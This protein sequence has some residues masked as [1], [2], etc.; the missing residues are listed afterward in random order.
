MAPRNGKDNQKPL[1]QWF[2]KG[3]L[4]PPVS[5]RKKGTPNKL[6]T[7]LKKVIL[8]AAAMV[9]RDGRGKEGLHGY[10]CKLAIQQP[11]I[12]GRLLEKLIPMHIKIGDDNAPAERYETVEELRTAMEARGLPA[13]ARIID[14]TPTAPQNGD[15]P[16]YG[17]EDEDRK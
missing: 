9:G 3:H 12:Y 17:V 2:T 1:K 11:K 5:G 15:E 13:P 10:L 4:K 6:S 14:V 16:L 8:E 7:E